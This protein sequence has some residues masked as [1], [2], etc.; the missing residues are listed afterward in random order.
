MATMPVQQGRWRRCNDG[1]DASNRVNTTGNNQPE[2]QKDKRADNRS[3]V[4]DMTGGNWVVEDTT[5]GG[6]LTTQGTYPVVAS[7]PTG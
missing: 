7:P 5:R 1:K 4:E 6:G 2:Q 3:G